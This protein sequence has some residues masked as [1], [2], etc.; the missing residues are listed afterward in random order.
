MMHTRRSPIAGCLTLAVSVLFFN[1]ASAEIIFQTHDPFGSLLG[2]NG[3]DVSRDQSVAARFQPAHAYTLDRV[4]LWLWNNDEN[5]REPLINITLET[6]NPAGGESRPSGTVLESWSL[7]VPSTGVFMPTLFTFNSALH[8]ALQNGGLYW[9][10]AR[11]PAMGGS[12]PVWAWAA[13]DSGWMSL[14]DHATSDQWS[15]A[16]TGAVASYIVEG[17]R[18][19]PVG[20]IDGDGHVGLSDLAL[21]LSSFGLCNG[22][23]GFNAAADLN[24]NLCV[25][26]SDLAIL[27][28]NF[29]T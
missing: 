3:F 22:Q 18:S 17:T 7:N 27:L 10:A 9:I 1:A 4:K 8:P 28:A 11:S 23:P 29:G 13:N 15:N 2:I 20:D 21:L 16:G 14:I 12:D 24:A 5:G 25:D 6:N 26:L 19:G